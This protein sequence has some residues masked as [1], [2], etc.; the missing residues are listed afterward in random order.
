M[1]TDDEKVRARHHLGYLNVGSASTFVLGVP[2]AVQTQF[3]I[4]GAFS[5]I[6]PAAEAR[7]RK[8]L[9]F[10]DDI[11]EQIVENT[12]NVAATGVDEINLNPNEFKD[13]L[14][15]YRH[16]QGGL[17]NM[18]GIVPNPFDQRPML[19]AGWGGGGGMN[20]RVNNG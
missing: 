7:F 16:W 13:L 4:E 5:K 20:V 17:A 11:E 6:L 9:Q 15:R 1:I 18:L 12:E 10:L 8:T 3:M 19:G 2:A 14:T